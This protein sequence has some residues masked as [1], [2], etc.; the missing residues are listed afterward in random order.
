MAFPACVQAPSQRL[1]A[2]AKLLYGIGEVPITVTMVLFGL[3][4]LFFYNS[5]MKLPAALVGVG[6]AAGLVLDAVLDPYIGYRSDGCR[7]PFGRRHIF[8]LAGA[9]AMGPCFFLL[10]SPPQSLG[11]AGLFCWL[12]ACSLAFRATSAVYRIPY[13]SLGAELS[14]DYDERT[15]V[16]GIRSL[17]GL[18]GT[19]GAA[20][21]SF[22]LFF[23]ETGDGVEPKLNYANYP[24]M[25]MAFGA[26]MTLS[27][28]AAVWGTLAHRRPQAARGERPA[29][30][31]FSGFAASMRNR[32]FRSIW[33]SCTLFFLGVVLNFALAI[34]FFTW[35]VRV[36]EAKTLSAIQT[37]FYL[38]ALGGVLVWIWL[39]RHAEKRNL[40]MA[41]TLATAV[42]LCGAS[43]LFGQGRLFGTGNALPLLIGHV[44][45]G[46][47]GSSVWV[48]PGSML[49]DVTDQD[50]LVTGLRREG[51][52]FGILNF[53][54]KIASGAALLVA[55]VL[56]HFFVRLAPGA[57]SQS[58]E[59]VERLGMLFGML[60]AAILVMAVSFVLPYGL[61]RRAVRD[62][63]QQLAERRK[64]Q[65]H[66]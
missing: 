27:G 63:Q 10:F 17:F 54:E 9:L 2:P 3:F 35:Y 34:H 1:S 5:V 66:A 31:F 52:F 61:N 12:L 49:A 53:G 36:H 60:P 37:S 62:I 46:I 41:G 6:I 59:A 7:H 11:S 4:A 18:L 42:I 56:L 58:P 43:L 13:L 21:L 64:E 40:Y 57:A 45:A 22:L 25:G 15:Q 23:P 30:R 8:M 65:V 14:Q 28:L 20:S 29:L 33:C 44:V 50:E 51:I 24:R 26:V 48:L 47:F 55:G 16:I 39:A 32:M 19:L 38:G